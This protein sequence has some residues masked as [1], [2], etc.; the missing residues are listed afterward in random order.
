MEVVA[1][2]A[3]KIV[4]KLLLLRTEMKHEVGLPNSVGFQERTKG[5]RTWTNGPWY[6]AESTV[7]QNSN[8]GPLVEQI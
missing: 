6:T 8:R 7:L 4:V 2:A 1:L 3:T 5:S